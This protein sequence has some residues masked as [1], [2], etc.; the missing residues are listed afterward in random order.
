MVVTSNVEDVS[1]PGEIM[2]E[3]ENQ[4]T[5]DKEW[6]S[7]FIKE[8]LQKKI[9]TVESDI[10]NIRNK[11]IRGTSKKQ[12]DMLKSLNEKLKVMRSTREKCEELAMTMEFL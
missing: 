10:D 5:L 6:L 1:D 11:K 7:S 2:Q 3:D 9:Q 4:L 8:K 12:K